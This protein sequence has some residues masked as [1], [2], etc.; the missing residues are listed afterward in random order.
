MEKF[1]VRMPQN[2]N[3]L[4]LY[5]VENMNDSCLITLAVNPKEYIEY[6]KSENL[7]KKQKHKGIKKGSVGMDYENFVERIK[8]L[9]DFDTYVKPKRDTK[10][11]VRISAKKGELTTHKI[12]KTKFSQLNEKNFYFPNVIISLPFGHSSLKEIDTFK[13]DKGQRIEWYFLK[14]KE[15][16]LELEK[17]ALK[18]CPRL[19]SLNN[20]LLQFV[21]VVS[22]NTNK[23]DEHTVFLHNKKTQRVIDF[24]LD[25]GWKN[26][27]ED[28][29]PTME[30]L[31]V[32]SS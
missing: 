15:R 2:Q 18:Q 13:R 28:I 4:G 16:M 5:E 30:S 8:P 14:E 1:D 23:F 12:T 32:T 22:L 31:Q 17:K 19:D 25:A 10:P 29:T 24:V 3:V 21:K 6:F 20:I 11:V 27:I 9:Y 26:N 7:K